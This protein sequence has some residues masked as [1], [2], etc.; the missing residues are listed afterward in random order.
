[1]GLTGLTSIDQVTPKY[2]CQAEPVTD[3]HEMSSWVNMPVA[4]FCSHSQI[5]LSCSYDL[6]HHPRHPTKPTRRTTRPRPKPAGTTSG[7]ST[8][9][10][11]GVA[12]ELR[13]T[14]AVRH[15]HAAAQRH[16]RPAQRPH[17]VRHAGRHHDPL[18]PHA[19][20]SEPV[21]ARPRSRGDRRPARRRARPE[22]QR[23]RSPRP[24]PRKVPGPDVGVDGV[25]TASRSSTSCASW[26]LRPTGRATCSP[27][28]RTTCARC[29]PRSCGCSKRG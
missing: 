11:A 20:R 9:S 17:A 16:G 10:S 14:A 4:V 25:A 8:T 7:S 19:R 23:P 1:M 28:T 29:G 2:V 13:Q 27:W 3:A 24:G 26:A 18:A 15:H 5:L 6:D 22:G 12:P 21:G